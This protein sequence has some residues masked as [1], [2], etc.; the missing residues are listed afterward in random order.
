MDG[1][2]DD[3]YHFNFTGVRSTL[4]G[5][6]GIRSRGTSLGSGKV[7]CEVCLVAGVGRR[8]RTDG[9]GHG[10]GLNSPLPVQ[11]CSKAEEIPF[12]LSEFSRGLGME[13]KVNGKIFD[14][15]LNS[16]SVVEGDHVQLK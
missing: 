8:T 10:H 16:L 6:D 9:H 4:E 14:T 2:T 13:V 1:V 3:R 5:R 12:F 7:G 11:V 15:V